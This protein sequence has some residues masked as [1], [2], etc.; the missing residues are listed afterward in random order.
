MAPPDAIA[1]VEV[2]KPVLGLR[3][4]AEVPSVVWVFEK[5]VLAYSNGR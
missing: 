3:V 2:T 1:V 5:G 4:P